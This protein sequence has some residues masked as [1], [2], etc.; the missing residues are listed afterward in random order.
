VDFKLTDSKSP[1][2]FTVDGYQLV[3]MPMLTAEA[4]AGDKAEVEAKP[5]AEAGGDTEP[6]EAGVIE[7]TEPEPEVEAEKAQAVAEAEAV[8]KAE[9][10]KR[11]RKRDKVAVA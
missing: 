1:V 6:G 8:V 3:V 5:Q 9:K 2:M 7:E 10:P 4:R 11:S